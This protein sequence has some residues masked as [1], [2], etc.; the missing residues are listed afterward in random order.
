[1]NQRLIRLAC[2]V[3]YQKQRSIVS[4]IASGWRALQFEV[5]AMIASR[6][7][8]GVRAPSYRKTSYQGAWVCTTIA[9]R[10]AASLLR[11]SFPIQHALTT[12]D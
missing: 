10:P 3:L 7:R 9:A 6:S 12:G 8:L 5:H 11:V 2:I 1:V 4:A